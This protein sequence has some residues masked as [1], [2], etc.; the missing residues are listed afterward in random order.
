MKAHT[1]FSEGLDIIASE[2]L[3]MVNQLIEE[4]KKHQDLLIEHNKILKDY[5]EVLTNY[6]KL[7]ERVTKED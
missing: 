5:A 2:Y 7:L 3:S 1:K 4:K 6:E